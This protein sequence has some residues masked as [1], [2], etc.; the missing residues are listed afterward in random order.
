M[1]SGLWVSGG[2]FNHPE[3]FLCKENN[4]TLLYYLF[5]QI[6]TSLLI[7]EFTRLGRDANVT[8]GVRST[9]PTGDQ[10]FTDRLLRTAC[11][12]YVPGRIRQEIWIIILKCGRAMLRT[13]QHR[14]YLDCAG[15]CRRK[16]VHYRCSAEISSPAFLLCASFLQSFRPGWTGAGAVVIVQ[17]FR[18]SW[19][20]FAY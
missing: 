1:A 12:T 6:S 2:P 17:I 3:H 7:Y 11:F 10:I 14:A 15:A 18:M 5:L 8:P 9:T 19:S 4:K 16:D 13:G 20:K